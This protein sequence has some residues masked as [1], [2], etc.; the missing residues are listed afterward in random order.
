M[1]C[2]QKF[3]ELD[4]RQ[5]DAI[6][7][8]SEKLC[9]TVLNYGATIQKIMVRGADGKQYDVCQGYDTVQEYAQNE[10]YFGAAIGRNG[11][12]IGNARYTYHGKTYQLRANEGGNQLHGGLFGLNA[13]L[14]AYETDENSVSF[15][16]AFAD[17]EEGYPG[18]LSV[19]VR[20]SIDGESG[21]RIDY[22]AETDADTV[23]NLTNHTYF[24]LNG[25]GSGTVMEHSVLIRAEAFTPVS[26]ALIPTGELR[27]VFGTCM[28][29]TREKKIGR[30]IDDEYLR[31]YGGYDHNFCVG[32]SGLR[33]VAYVRADASGI[34]MSVESTL[35]GLQFYTG[36]MLTP[37][38]RK[39]GK[40]YDKHYAFCMETQHYP[41]AVNH[42][43]FKSSILKKG[44][45]LHETTIY[46]FQ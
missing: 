37:R 17:G 40:F 9:F 20:Y 39:E 43:N 32:G 18:N 44:E 23:A 21:L 14:C 19:T 41:D 13:K 15:H 11:N 27:P 38:V 7:L 31:P 33:E 25:A 4:G 12:R 42:E 8:R 34:S 3:G 22:F 24:N 5:V 46:R 16:A 45:K 36:N 1:V 30:D 6:T 29:F 28:D 35:E 10:G 26:D 2:I